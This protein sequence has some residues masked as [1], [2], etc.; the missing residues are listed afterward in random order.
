[1]KLILNRRVDEM[2]CAA[3]DVLGNTRLPFYAAR[4]A[5]CSSRTRSR[6][7]SQGDVGS[8]CARDVEADLVQLSQQELVA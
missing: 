8:S 1:M 6:Y 4:F 5:L 7:Q 3:R 2:T